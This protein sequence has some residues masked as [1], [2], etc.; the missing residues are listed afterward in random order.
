MATPD[1]GVTLMTIANG[2]KVKGGWE[3]LSPVLRDVIET[4]LPAY[5]DAPTGRDRPG[6]GVS[7]WSYFA[8]PDVLKAYK[9]GVV[10]PLHDPPMSS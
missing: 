9:E 8:R 6:G 10:F 1:T 5:K 4:K 7:S 3:A 2:A